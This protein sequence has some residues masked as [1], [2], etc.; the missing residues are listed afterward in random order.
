[1]QFQPS[2]HNNINMPAGKQCVIIAIPAPNQPPMRSFGGKRHEML[3][4]M[5]RKAI[6][7]CGG[8][9]GFR[10]VSAGAG[11]YRLAIQR[12]AL[13]RRTN[14]AF[15]EDRLVNYAQHRPAILH[16]RDQC[17]E[18]GSAC[19]KARGAINR[20]KHPLPRGTFALSAEFLANNPV[21]WAFGEQQLADG[22]LCGLIRQGDWRGISLGFQPKLR[23]VKGADGS[24]GCI[25]KAVGQVNV[26]VQNH[27][28]SIASVRQSRKR[29]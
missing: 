16:Q 29:R 17:A 19:N 15:L 25:G 14:P 27:G 5:G 4:F 3:A 8:K 2:L 7:A 10:K 26:I 6:G 13:P 23:A 11:F 22:S 18:N 9:N 1:M 21:A 24:P 12:R 28:Q 20:I